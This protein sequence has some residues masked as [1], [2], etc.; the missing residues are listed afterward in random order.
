MSTQKERVLTITANGDYPLFVPGPAQISIDIGTAATVTAFGYTEAKGKGAP[1]IDNRTGAAYSVTADD[2]F[3]F[4]GGYI[5]FTV[6]GISG[7]LTIIAAPQ[8][9]QTIPG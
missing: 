4:G 1:I 3:Q 5:N 9:V 7:T 6:A 8:F 2:V